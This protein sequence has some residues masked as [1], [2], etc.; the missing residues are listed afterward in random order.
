MMATTSP[1]TIIAGYF[2]AFTAVN[3]P[4]RLPDIEYSDHQYWITQYG[5]TH[6]VGWLPTEFTLAT[7]RL[8]KQANP[9]VARSMTDL[10]TAQAEIKAHRK[11]VRDSAGHFV[12]AEVAVQERLTRERLAERIRSELRAMGFVVVRAR[13]R[14]LH[15]KPSQPQGFL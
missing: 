12:R 3:G 11:L 1:S 2:A 13:I 9:K 10:L 4:A 15:E 8:W 7:E 6:A 5:G 14:H